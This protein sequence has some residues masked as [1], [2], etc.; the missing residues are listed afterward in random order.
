MPSLNKSYRERQIPYDLAHMWNLKMT[1]QPQL[2]NTENGLLVARG[3]DW[4]W[5]KMSEGGRKVQT[6]G[7]KMN[8]SWGRN[9]QLGVYS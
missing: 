7:Y 8:K 9:L 3:G 4:G 6:S 1:K 2:I 5:T